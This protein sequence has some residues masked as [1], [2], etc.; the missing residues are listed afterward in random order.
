[1]RLEIPAFC[2]EAEERLWSHRFR[3]GLFHGHG[4]TPK[5][6]VGNIRFFM[7]DDSGYPNLW[8]PPGHEGDI[9]V[10]LMNTS[11]RTPLRYVVM[12]SGAM[13]SGP[14]KMQ[15]LRWLEVLCPVL[16]P[17]GVEPWQIHWSRGGSRF[18]DLLQWGNEDSIGIWIS[19]L[20]S[21]ARWCIFSCFFFLTCWPC[22]RGY[23]T[24]WL[25]ILSFWQEHETTWRRYL[26]IKCR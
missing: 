13:V 8:N 1:M 6:W 11:S 4:A 25:A 18:D 16:H 14:L 12:G 7:G 15:L 2:Q 19:P 3:A 23:P 24:F 21:K 10:F 17:E 9:A 22:E 20:L 26:R 5:W